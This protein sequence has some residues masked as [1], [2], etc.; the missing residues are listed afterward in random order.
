MN[1]PSA[2]P[3]ENM[4]TASTINPM[5]ARRAE[6]WL[7]VID[8]FARKFM[9]DYLREA[10]QPSRLSGN[11]KSFSRHSEMCPLAQARN[12]GSYCRHNT[13]AVLVPQQ[14]FSQD[15]RHDRVRSRAASHGAGPTLV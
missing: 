10:R 14:L 15:I 7:V 4:K 3:N 11:R 8:I 6:R 2:S 9:C 12:D 5:P 13:S 1:L